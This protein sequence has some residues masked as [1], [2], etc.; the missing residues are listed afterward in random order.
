MKVKCNVCSQVKDSNEDF[1]WSKGKRMIR[2]KEC[3]LVY[4]NLWRKQHK[5]KVL[6]HRKKYNKKYRERMKS[7][8]DS[9]S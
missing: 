9:E 1:Y 7:V 5:E 3:H 8:S 4:V 2:C 6:E